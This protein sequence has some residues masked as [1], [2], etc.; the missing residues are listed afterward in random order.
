ME[1]CQ[2]IEL[3]NGEVTLLGEHHS[4]DR[5]RRLFN[6]N[7][8]TP[9]EAGRKFSLFRIQQAPVHVLL[10]LSH[11]HTSVPLESP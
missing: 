9:S 6:R 2:P 4:I 7:F 1:H 5:V 3:T 10:S 8:V 11:R